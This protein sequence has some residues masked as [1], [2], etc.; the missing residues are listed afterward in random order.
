MITVAPSSSV[1]TRTR[2]PLRERVSSGLDR[3][4][5]RLRPRPL[6]D[7]DVEA[8]VRGVLRSPAREHVHARADRGC[9]VLSGAIGTVDRSDVVHDVA[10]IPGVDSVIDLMSERVSVVSHREP[11]AE[12]VAPA[13]RPRL[14]GF[15][16]P[17][18]AGVGLGLAVAGLRL[19][20]R[21]GLSLAAL[22]IVLLAKGIGRPVVRARP[23]M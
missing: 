12:A 7:G 22:G 15:D 18:L 21:S 6:T 5:R 2:R 17:V 23:T 16:H 8:R 1:S 19:R 13:A 10:R 20:T 14:L 3:V 4:A 9:V 11:V